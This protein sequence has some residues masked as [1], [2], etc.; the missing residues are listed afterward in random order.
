M[1]PTITSE[2]ICVRGY[3]D[4]KMI[5]RT[6]TCLCF[7]FAVVIPSHPSLR[8]AFDPILPPSNML[9]QSPNL[10]FSILW[11]VTLLALIRAP[12]LF[13]PSL[14]PRPAL[15]GSFIP[16]FSLSSTHFPMSNM[17]RLPS[18]PQVK[19]ETFLWVRITPLHY[20]ASPEDKL[21]LGNGVFHIPF[22]FIYPRWSLLSSRVST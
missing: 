11:L 21:H 3:C 22:T 7:P 4:S 2:S 10:S 8:L 19:V 15:L 14:Y 13:D 9:S 16:P 5:T 17:P 12:F 20:T 1:W 18:P 6:H